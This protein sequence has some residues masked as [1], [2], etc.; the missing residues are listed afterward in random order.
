MKYIVETDLEHFK[1]WSGATDVMT[2]IYEKGCYDEAAQLVE[3]VFWG[4]DGPTETTETSI[5]DY[6]WFQLASDLYNY[7]YIDLWDEHEE[8]EE[9]EDFIPF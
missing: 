9:E 1:T 4:W 5:N 2:Q 8:E 3:E 7:Y 6:I